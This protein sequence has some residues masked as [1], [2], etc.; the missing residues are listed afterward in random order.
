MLRSSSAFFPHHLPAIP[1][2]CLFSCSHLS[3]PFIPPL[4]GSLVFLS[5]VWPELT[6]EGREERVNISLVLESKQAFLKLWS[7]Q[8]QFP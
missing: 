4:P 8:R 6:A 5:Q 2:H 7:K 1:P 3:F